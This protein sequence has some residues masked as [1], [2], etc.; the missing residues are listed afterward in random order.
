MLGVIVNAAAIVVGSLLGLLM[1][2]GIRESFRRT[3]LDVI[4]LSVVVIGII[5]AIQTRMVLLMVISLVLGSLLGEAIRIEDRLNQGGLWLE[6]RLVGE[7]N[8]LARGFVSASLI[9][10]VGSMAI[11]GSIESGL[12]GQH[13][14]LLAKAV[15][16]GVFSIFFASTM[17]IGVAFSAI[18]VLIYEGILTLS[19]AGIKPLFTDAMVLELTAVGGVLILA[20]GLNQLRL[21]KLKIG[22]L[23]PSLLVP[24]LYFIVQRVFFPLG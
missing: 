2:K 17:G 7:G 4:A 14:T 3:I 18:P 22:N 20:I 15:L 19:A 1:R 12:S 11:I 13:A 5:S 9:F 10:C 21:T 6:R 23:L 24:L 16:D 8:G